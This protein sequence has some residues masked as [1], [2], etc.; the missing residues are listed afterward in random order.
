MTLLDGEEM[1]DLQ[2][3]SSAAEGASGYTDSYIFQS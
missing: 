2:A 1:R 3:Y